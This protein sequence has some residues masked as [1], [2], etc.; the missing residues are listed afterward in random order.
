M[1]REKALSISDLLWKILVPVLLSFA[2]YL[3]QN[4]SNQLAELKQEIRA[5]RVDYQSMSV[6]IAMLKTRLQYHEAV[7]Q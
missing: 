6:E 1:T 3:L 5:M 7:K 2:A 4:A